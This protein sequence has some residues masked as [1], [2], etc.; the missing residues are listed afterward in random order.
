MYLPLCLA[1]FSVPIYVFTWWEA[2]NPGGGWEFES[3]K[4]LYYGLSWPTPHSLPISNK[5]KS[6]EHPAS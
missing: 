2:R 6:H 4:V 1:A 3:P 5:T